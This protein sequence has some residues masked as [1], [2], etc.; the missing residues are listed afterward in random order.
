[1]SSQATP[2]RL[3]RAISAAREFLALG[4]ICSGLIAAGCGSGESDPEGLQVR[5]DPLQVVAPGQRPRPQFHDFGDVTFGAT[6]EHTFSIENRDDR[7]VR[8]LRALPSCS[9]TVPDLVAFSADGERIEADPS[10]P[11]ALIRVPADGRLE[12]TLRITTHTLRE[13][14]IDKLVQVRLQS[15]S[16]STPFLTL[17]A[18][19]RALTEFRVVPEE[20][21][22]RSVPHSRG[23]T[24]RVEYLPTGHGQLR[25]VGVR[26]TPE[27][28]EVEMFP[29]PLGNE[30]ATSV[31]LYLAS[32]LP[33][34][35]RKGELR[36]ITE[37][38]DGEPGPDLKL[39]WRALIKP[40]L[41]YEPSQFLLLPDKERGG[42][43]QT[44]AVGTH[45]ER[46]AFRVDAVSPSGSGSG[47]LEIDV[48]PATTTHESGTASRW[49]I[50]VHWP[51][52]ALP[53]PLPE[54][55]VGELRVRFA[56][57]DDLEPLVI[58]Y[59]GL[60]R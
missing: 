31:L 32:D 4:L 51:E 7:E 36:L 50:H 19:F 15:D 24:L 49:H 33:V 22:F 44:V 47:G 3:P 25:I 16:A 40:D 43:S 59:T 42:L 52:A 26:E 35:L 11:D 21:D 2:K 37:R 9:C 57:D 6:F 38:V 13:A 34:G 23:A 29:N 46:H 8:V 27:E 58:P 55:A 14:N 10:N 54:S 48:Q 17:E 45:R 1:M 12:L 30:R 53:D 5:L 60:F 56:S 20:A 18:H 39:P 41:Y 28:I